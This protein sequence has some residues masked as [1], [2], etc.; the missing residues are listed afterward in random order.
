MNEH[1]VTPGVLVALDDLVVGNLGESLAL[2]HTFDVADGLTG[3]GMDHAKGDPALRRGRMQPDRDQHK[4]QA[5][6]AGP[7]GRRHD[8]KLNLRGESESGAQPR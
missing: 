1:M 8:A 4:R 6:I 2:A 5:E 3:W 7:E